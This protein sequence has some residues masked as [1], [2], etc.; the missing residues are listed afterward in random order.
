MGFWSFA[1]TMEKNCGQFVV[2]GFF[3][4][5]TVNSR[6]KSLKHGWVNLLPHIC[7]GPYRLGTS[8]V[9]VSQHST[10]RVTEHR[11]PSAGEWPHYQHLM[12]QDLAQCSRQP[13]RQY[14]RRAHQPAHGSP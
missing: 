14:Q 8:N 4:V 1:E 9:L 12:R 11:T 5:E 13:M 2:T 10:L 3:F 7:W 6:T